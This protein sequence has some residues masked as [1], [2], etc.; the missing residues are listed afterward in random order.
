LK[1]QLAHW[2]DR[3][4][5]LLVEA[6]VDAGAR[7]RDQRPGLDG[8]LKD[9]SRRKFD[10]VMA[11]AIDRL[12]RSLID[13]LETIKHHEAV[14]DAQAHDIACASRVISRQHQLSTPGRHQPMVHE[15]VL[16]INRRQI[17]TRLRYPSGRFFAWR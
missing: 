2:R 11:W 14:A 8:M 9:A 5:V 12:G 3:I 1:E 10:V 7:G 15:C 6:T 16:M 13:L 4:D 17:R